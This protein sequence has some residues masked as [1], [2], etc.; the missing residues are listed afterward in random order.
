LPEATAQRIALELRGAPGNGQGAMHGGQ[1]SAPT[2][3]PPAVHDAAESSHGAM[4]AGQ[5]QQLT[6]IVSSLPTI[7]VSDLRKGDVVMIVSTQGATFAS[8]TAIKLV[9]GAGPI[10]TT[11]S[12]RNQSSAMQSLWSGFG[13]SQGEG[14][15]GGGAAMPSGPTSQ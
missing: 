1:Q 5:Q 3:Q 6:K 13:G 8:A 14:G 4:Q 15:A 2:G 7:T 11:P 9:N 12:A 10:L